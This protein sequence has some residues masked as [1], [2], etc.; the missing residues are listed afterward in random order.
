M[1]VCTSNGRDTYECYTKKMGTITRK[2][3]INLHD[4]YEKQDT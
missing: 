4:T 1:F 2:K 3:S